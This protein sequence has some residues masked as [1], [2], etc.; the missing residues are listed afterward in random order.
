MCTSQIR[1]FAPTESVS[2]SII[3]GSVIETGKFEGFRL[4]ME[5]RSSD[6]NLLNGESG[7][8]GAIGMLII[9]MVRI[10]I[11]LLFRLVSL[12]LSSCKGQTGR[13]DALQTGYLIDYA[14]MYN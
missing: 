7:L 11:A 8:I 12:A 9:T 10:N 6:I 1:T 2:K 13:S 14:M 3:R 5:T 4:D